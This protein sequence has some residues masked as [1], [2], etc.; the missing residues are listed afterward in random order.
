MIHANMN[1]D[2]NEVQ[3]KGKEQ[4]LIVEMFLI[5]NKV[6]KNI[7]N[8]EAKKEVLKDLKGISECGDV[9]LHFAKN[10]KKIM[11]V[12]TISIN[13]KDPAEALKMLEKMGFPE[14]VEKIV[15]DALEDAMKNN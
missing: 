3:I 2:K 10:K 5:I 12:K 4:D 7:K 8:K 6:L 1:K 15:K 9:E 13:T 11:K 14:E